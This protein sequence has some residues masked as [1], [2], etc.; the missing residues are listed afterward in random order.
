MNKYGD[1][2]ESVWESLHVRIFV[3][4]CVSVRVFNVTTCLSVCASL[5]VCTCGS[6]H[7]FLCHVVVSL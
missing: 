1:L 2:C 6:L 7:V 4:V 5:F 3:C